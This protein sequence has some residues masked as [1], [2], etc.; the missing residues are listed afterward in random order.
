MPIAPAFSGESQVANQGS[1]VKARPHA[2]ERPD[3]TI[4]LVYERG[5][6]GTIV[7]YQIYDP[8]LGTWGSPVDVSTQA[9]VPTNNP[10]VMA[11]AMDLD[12]NIMI[13]WSTGAG[14]NQGI[15]ARRFKTDDTFDTPVKLSTS[16]ATVPMGI[17]GRNANVFNIAQVVSGTDIRLYTYAPGSNTWDAG[18]IVV[19]RGGGVGS[20]ANIRLVHGV[21]DD[22]VH[23]VWTEVISG[24]YAR[25]AA[26]ANSTSWA[27]VEFPSIQHATYTSNTPKI[28]VSRTSSADVWCIFQRDEGAGN[29]RVVINKRASGSWGSESDL[30]ANADAGQ[31]QPDL[32][33]DLDNNVHLVWSDSYA[34]DQEIFYTRII[35]F[36]SAPESVRGTHT[37]VS[38]NSGQSRRAYVCRRM[39][40]VA[41][42]EMYVFWEDTTTGTFLVYWNVC[43]NCIPSPAPIGGSCL[44]IQK[45]A[46]L[47]TLDHYTIE[48]ATMR[49]WGG[50][51]VVS[52]AD[53]ATPLPTVATTPGRGTL[54]LDKS[55]RIVADGLIAA[56]GFRQEQAVV[57]DPI[58]TVYLV[59]AYQSG[60]NIKIRGVIPTDRAI[61]GAGLYEFAGGDFAVLRNDFIGLWI[62]DSA[63]VELGNQELITPPLQSVYQWD[64]LVLP[65]A[66]D[67]L[68]AE[69]AL[70]DVELST[71][72]R[73]ALSGEVEVQLAYVADGTNENTEGNQEFLSGTNAFPDA[74][75]TDPA[76]LFDDLASTYA[77]VAATLTGNVYYNLDGAVGPLC[78]HRVEA[79]FSAIP[80]GGSLVVYTSEDESVAK[81]LVGAQAITDWEEIATIDATWIMATPNTT[82]PHIPI[83]RRAKWVR[84]EIIGGSAVA[85]EVRMFEIQVMILPVLDGKCPPH[86]TSTLHE[87]IWV[88]AD[89]HRLAPQRSAG[90]AVATVATDKVLSL[91]ALGDSQFFAQIQANDVIW[92]VDGTLD[93]NAADRARSGIVDTKNPVAKTITLKNPIGQVFPIGAAVSPPALLLRA[94]AKDASEAQIARTP[95]VPFIATADRWTRTRAG[96][97]VPN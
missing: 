90:L 88:D 42:T 49:V 16:A 38:N 36:G 5:S 74:N 64:D 26:Y 72:C 35:G 11:A 18:T 73:G 70:L 25:Y 21:A 63:T 3:G 60:S 95:W 81:T 28:A 17:C 12:G 6:T 7:F 92:V 75:V 78:V 8:T 51:P 57:A 43:L 91:D 53:G 80:A 62:V 30:D 84:L 68:P 48:A 94:K 86:P 37:Q 67:T 69:D 24:T 79:L 27:T 19:A 54:Y 96:A 89:G 61:D 9:S 13:C 34:T 41:G 23:A 77:S 93:R 52:G 32:T 87:R 15:Y 39:G 82:G 31:Q 46:A 97:T 20:M 59:I 33:T 65:G 4:V 58:G 55:N 10:G 71:W 40:G 45:D 83:A 1:T 85:T 44:V 29:S 47:T 2:F 22:S 56:W 14:V 66:G 76:N 50:G